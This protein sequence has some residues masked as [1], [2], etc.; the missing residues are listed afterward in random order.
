MN[1][2]AILPE[3][4]QEH[5]GRGTGW[6][7][8][9]RHYVRTPLISEGLL[10]V[11][12]CEIPPGSSQ[13][14]L[15]QI[16]LWSDVWGSLGTLINVVEGPII[17]KLMRDIP[18]DSHLHMR[19]LPWGYVRYSWVQNIWGTFCMTIVKFEDHNLV[20]FSPTGLEHFYIHF[21]F[22]EPHLFPLLRGKLIILFRSGNS[23]V[24]VPIKT[25]WPGSHFDPVWWPYITPSC[26]IRWQSY[27]L[28]LR[29]LAFVP[30]F[31]RQRQCF[32]LPSYRKKMEVFTN[33]FTRAKKGVWR[34][35]RCPS[36]PHQS[37]TPLSGWWPARVS[38]PLTPVPNTCIHSHPL[39]LLCRVGKHASNPIWEQKIWINNSWR[40]KN[41]LLLNTWKYIQPH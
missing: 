2:D 7:A 3:D 12:P 5:W 40:R 16:C 33:W 9:V 10:S 11:N 19:D 20:T 27:N 26:S 34:V 35:P 4:S 24:K 13:I 38:P 39:Q 32:P 30:P 8:D 15:G 17:H 1:S 37:S 21:D 36:A 29:R 28:T 22:L 23:F 41:K 14:Y 25:C 31:L 18:G 6:G